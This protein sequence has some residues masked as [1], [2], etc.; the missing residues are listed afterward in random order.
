[1]NAIRAAFAILLLLSCSCAQATDTYKD[2]QRAFD[3]A[4]SEYKA[5]YQELN[6]T[7]EHCSLGKRTDIDFNAVAKKIP[8][9]LTKLQL[10]AALYLMRKLH[11]D[12]CEHN[13][14]GNYMQKAHS[15]KSLLDLLEAK[16]IILSTGKKIE[17]IRKLLI[18]R[19]QTIFF[20]PDTYLS[21]LANYQSMSAQDRSKIESI[22]ELKSDYNLVSLLNALEQRA[23]K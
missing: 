20:V 5:A 13:A 11:F 4:Y 17:D 18:S 16:K 6:K 8:R 1:M 15:L 7:V 12:M 2:Y 23:A 19:E 14:L 10:S 21:L 22:A 3:V 9:G